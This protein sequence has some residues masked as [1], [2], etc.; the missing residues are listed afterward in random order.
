MKALAPLALIAALAATPVA[1]ALEVTFYPGE[2]VYAYEADVQRGA[3]TLIVHNIGIRNDA[4]TPVALGSVAIELM[5]GERAIDG[6]A[7]GPE[8]LTRAAASGAGLQQAGMYDMLAFQFGGARLLPAGTQLSS[9][10]ML[11]PGEAIIVTS[12]IF[13]YRGVRNAVRVRVNGAAAEA[14]IP[15]RTDVSQTIFTVPLR[16]QWYNGAGSTFHSHH[17]W[18]PMEEFA[19]DFVRLGSDFTTHRRDGLRFSDYYAYGEQVF[20]AAEGRVVSVIADQLE[21]VGAMRGA[22]EPIEQYFA[23]LQQDQQTRLARGRAGITGNSVVIDHGNGEFSFYAHLK[24]GS[25]RVRE[26]DQ[27]GRGQRIG[28]VGSSGNSTEPHLHFQ[29]CDSPD[30]LLCAGI[31]VQFEASEDPLGEPP[32]APQ[33]GEFLSRPDNSGARPH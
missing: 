18:S 12:Q 9:D 17:R 20:A 13:A 10:L 25:V 24:P 6:R 15:I 31:P 29:V 19:F 14:R 27:V 5:S 21:D 11:D 23:R 7:L 4:A 16:G 2:R 30:P 28:Q 26:G 1:E 22:D 3:R 33:T 8:E 32:H